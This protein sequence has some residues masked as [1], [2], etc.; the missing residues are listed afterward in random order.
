[1]THYTAA[2][3]AM[4]DRHIAE[5]E[6]H[7]VRQEELL[8]FLRLRGQPTGEAETLLRLFNET[9]VEHWVHRKAIARALEEVIGP[10][11]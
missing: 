10:R 11:H 7:I 2:D 4:A 1:M 3:L 5:G 8:T 6:A 9:Q